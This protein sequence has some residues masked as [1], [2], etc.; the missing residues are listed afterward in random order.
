M[1]PNHKLNEIRNSLK[2]EYDPK[3]MIGT[4]LKYHRIKQKKTLEYISKKTKMSISYL[5]KLE[6]NII[7]VTHKNGK[8]IVNEL[9]INE[10]VLL[11]NQNMSY[12]YD[13]LLS[14]VLKT[15]EDYSDLLDLI[16]SRDDFQAKLIDFTLRIINKE[17]HGSEMHVT[18]LLNQIDKMKAIESSIL[19][20][21]F[22]HYSYITEDYTSAVNYLDLMKDTPVDNSKLQ[23]WIKAM[24]YKLA[25]LSGNFTFIEKKYEE[26]TL[27]LRKHKLEHIVKEIDT[28]FLAYGQFIAPPD[29]FLKLEKVSEC[30]SIRSMGYLNKL[31]Y[32]SDQSIVDMIILDDQASAFVK[33]IAFWIIEDKA[34][35]EHA[36]NQID[37]TKLHRIETHILDYLH[38]TKDNPDC[39]HTLRNIVFIDKFVMNNH[40]LIHLY[41]NILASKYAEIHKYKDSVKVTEYISERKKYIKENYYWS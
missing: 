7:Q 36:F 4:T 37:K 29:Y 16:D 35:F 34:N 17:I 26:T 28:D 18:L 5:S 23:I 22:A 31:C 12:W 10:D 33:A 32:N 39:I 3:P 13:E 27:L 25:L 40:I 14:V 38:K 41:G 2:K 15:K 21:T 20:M 11:F 6:N 19:M 1:K 30:H 9:S 8:R 24:E